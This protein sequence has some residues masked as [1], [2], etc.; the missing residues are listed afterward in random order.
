MKRWLDSLYGPYSINRW[1][2]F[3]TLVVALV[4][5]PQ[6]SVA[7]KVPLFDWIV[8]VVIVHIACIPILFFARWNIQ[9]IDA[10]RLR[11]AC[12]ITHF[13]LFGA[14]RAFALSIYAARYHDGNFAKLLQG[15]LPSYISIAT[16]TL[17]GVA[18]VINRFRAHAATMARLEGLQRN[19]EAIREAE[20]VEIRSMQEEL[21]C[22]RS[23]PGKP[24]RTPGK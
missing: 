13:A 9:K 4:N 7:N 22:Q 20:D 23:N 3:V 21:L 1:S 19:L 10:F 5:S 11:I 12:T 18:V 14:F 16:V 6:L 8:A 2:W 17:I 24:T 15:A